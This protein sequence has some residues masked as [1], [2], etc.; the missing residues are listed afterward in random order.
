MPARHRHLHTI[1]PTWPLCIERLFLW[2]NLQ[3]EVLVLLATRRSR[4][5]RSCTGLRASTPACR[6]AEARQLPSP[7]DRVVL[8]REDASR[9][10]LLHAGKVGVDMPALAVDEKTYSGLARGLR[11]AVVLPTLFATSSSGNP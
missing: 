1:R 2:R 6:S 7:P 11:A 8:E 9:S 10:S 4:V 3:C 5:T